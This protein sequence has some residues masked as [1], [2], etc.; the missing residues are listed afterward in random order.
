MPPEE[1]SLTAAV[2]GRYAIEGVVG[3]GGAATVYRAHDLRHDRAVA[4]KSLRPELASAVG[5]DRFLAEIRIAAGLSHPHIVPL[6]DS[7]GAGGSLFYVM[8]LMAGESLRDRLSREGRLDVETALQFTREVA[9]ALGYAHRQGLVHRD[10]KP[11]NVLLFEGHAAVADFGIARALLAAGGDRLTQTGFLVGTPAYMSPEQAAGDPDLDGRSDLFSLGCMLYEM[12]TGEIPFRAAT[13]AASMALRFTESAVPV[14]AR[15][16]EVD[17]ALSGVVARAMAREP[18]DRYRDAGE[19]ARAL[20]TSEHTARAATRKAIAVLPFANLSS[21]AEN[22]YFS[23]G[24]TEELIA[25]LSKVGALRVTSRTSAMLL[26][27]TKDDLRTIGRRLGVQ[28]LLEGSVRKSGASL[29]IS[30]QL[31]DAATDAHLWSD[32][33]AGT[34]DDVFDLQERVSREIVRALG[35]TLSPGEDRRLAAHPLAD[36]RVLDC[37]LRAR[38][39]LYRMTTGSIDA[40]TKLLLEGLALSP[41]NSLLEVALGMGEVSRAKTEAGYDERLL[42]QAD[43]RG[44]RAAQ[45]DPGLPHGPFLLGLVA[46]ERG[47]LPVAA[48]QLR[49]ALAVDPGFPDAL[50]Y[51]VLT[52]FYAGH[53]MPARAVAQRHVDTDP[54]SPMSWAMLGALEWCDGRFAASLSPMRRSMELDPGNFIVRWMHGYTLALN[55]DFTLAAVDAEFMTRVSPDSPYTRQLAGLVAGVT[56]RRD[57]A[58]ALLAPLDRV[59]LDHHESFHVAESYAAA[60]EGERAL[61]MIEDGIGKGFHPYEFIATHNPLLAPVRALPGFRRV[62]ELARERWR[63]FTP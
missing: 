33:Y 41:G 52:Y 39:E 60:G 59:H 31:I 27:G 54:L 7:G 23:D 48:R 13:A 44:R 37:Y 22:E 46:F 26:K 29:R 32:K 24:L 34:M 25:D 62:A 30:A 10:I 57:E 43:G 63:A 38:H 35:V 1:A 12:L 9:D 58:L 45:Q 20:A 49:A 4:L 6:Y 15:R 5:A 47:D 51:L 28:Y 55:G 2:T 61:A 42:A 14:H 18:A 16:P 40:S 19:F 36:P 21:D 56:G 53:Q 17:E 11:E 8:P 50:M 3:E